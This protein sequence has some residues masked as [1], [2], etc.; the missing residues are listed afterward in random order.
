MNALIERCADTHTHPLCRGYENF[1]DIPTRLLFVGNAAE[2][3]LMRIFTTSKA[4]GAPAYLALSHCWVDVDA[5]AAW[6]LRT[7]NEGRYQL[8]FS[9]DLLPKTF[10][11][12][13]QITRELGQSY[14]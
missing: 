8:G 3:S 12:A 13:V 14:V 7:S 10:A 11:D 9:E 2:R 6:Q 4:T 1:T 5:S